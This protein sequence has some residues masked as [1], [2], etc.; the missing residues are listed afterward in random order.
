MELF[1]LHLAVLPGGHGARFYHIVSPF[2]VAIMIS[3]Y[4][5]DLQKAR[6][7]LRCVNPGVGIRYGHPVTQGGMGKEVVLGLCYF[8]PRE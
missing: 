8:F 3:P 1:R 2:C 7:I 5:G 4:H 6:V